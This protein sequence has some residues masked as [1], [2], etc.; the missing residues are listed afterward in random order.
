M[1]RAFANDAFSRFITS[2]KRG[3]SREEAWKT[4]AQ[5][6]GSWALVGF[7]PWVAE[8]LASGAPVGRIG[9]YAAE[10]WPDFEIGWS[11]FPEFR[12]RGYAVEGAAAAIEW[13]HNA[14]GRN[15]VIHL[16]HPLNKVSQR[17]ARALG[18]ELTSEWEWPSSERTEIW[19]TSWERFTASSA[20]SGCH[21][22]RLGGRVA[23]A[24]PR[25]RSAL[26]G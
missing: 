24:A 25:S 11:I 13:V 14:L 6:A 20:H 7:G 1:I 10:G 18:A 23:R 5:V 12:G 21:E 19:T 3:L 16:I 17:V 2:Q 9:P 8:E 15:H 4:M 22:D 26:D